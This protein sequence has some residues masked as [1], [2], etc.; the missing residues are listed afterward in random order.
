MSEHLINKIINET[1]FTMSVEGFVLPEDEKSALRK[2]L[3]GDIPFTV[4]LE[5]YIQNAKMAG[6]ITHA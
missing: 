2:V 4:Q 1:V 6:A 3:S 5:E